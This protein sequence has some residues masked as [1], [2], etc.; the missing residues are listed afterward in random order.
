M[1][2]RIVL[3]TTPPSSSVQPFPI[4]SNE[5]SA[6]FS[7][8]RAVAILVFVLRTS[9]SS[10]VDHGDR[11]SRAALYMDCWLLFHRV[12]GNSCFLCLVLYPLH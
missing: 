1:R 9:S 5:I 7:S 12:V 10:G 11:Y 8:L 4:A 6:P 2:P 3:Q